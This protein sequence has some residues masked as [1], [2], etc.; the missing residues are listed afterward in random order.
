MSR[1]YSKAN[2]DSAE[3]NPVLMSA[4]GGPG[5]AG[6]PGLPVTAHAP[7]SA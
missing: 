7:D 2:I 3:Y 6:A 4:I 1:E 5:L